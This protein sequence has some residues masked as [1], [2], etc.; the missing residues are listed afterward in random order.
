LPFKVTIPE[1]ERDPRLFD[2]LISELPGIFAWAIQGC[3]EWQREGLSPPAGVRDEV[4]AYRQSED[5][6]S[7]WL[8]ERCVTGSEYRATAKTLLDSFKD[9]SNWRHL[10]ATKFGRML[11]DA[12]F[13]KGKSGKRYWHGVSMKV[14]GLD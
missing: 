2:K 9:F 14:D 1:G 10:S 12:G 7:Q 3:L 8:D 6:F 4:D 5:I 13:T 11:S